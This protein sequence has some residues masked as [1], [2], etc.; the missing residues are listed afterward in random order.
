MATLFDNSF[1]RLPDQFYTL[2]NPV[3]VADPTLI[4]VN[5]KLARDLGIN[6]KTLTADILSGNQVPE[7]AEPLAQ[8]YSGHQFGNWAG[9][10]GDGRAVLLGEIAG[11]DIVL[12]GAGRT[13]YSRGG[14]GRA[15][16]GP[17]LREYV[18]SEAMAALNVPTT[19]ALGVVMTGENV[20]RETALPGAILTRVAASH[21]RVG[22]FTAF[23][24]GSGP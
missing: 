23:C 15:W 9:Q 6:P 10:L 12:K 16:L 3:P 14:D 2:Q 22:T 24:R 5:E 8:V 21:V 1:A 17:V 20:Q 18:V 19:R 7:G 11:F 4:V 13:P